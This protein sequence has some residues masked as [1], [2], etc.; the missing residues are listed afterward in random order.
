M[1]GIDMSLTF[2][3]SEILEMAIEIERNGQKFYKKA[4][5][6][7]ADSNVKKFLLDIADMEVRHEKIFREMKE[8]LAEKQVAVFD[9]DNEASL[10]LQAMADG[11]VFDLKTDLSRKLTGKEPVDQIFRMA[12]QAEKDSIVYYVGLEDYVDG[13]ESKEKV[14]K[15]IEEEKGHIIALYNQL[16]QYK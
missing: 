7:V 1:E 11:N 13:K 14:D 3:V 15:I 6:I 2:N 16:R 5:Q 8:Q 12:V 10:Y 9:P 4:A